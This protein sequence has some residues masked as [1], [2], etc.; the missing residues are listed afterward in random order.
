M[1]TSAALISFDQC[2]FVIYFLFLIP[3]FF[4]LSN[5]HSLNISMSNTIKCPNC[6][7]QFPMEQAVSEEYRK[8]LREKMLEFKKTKEEEMA[9]KE[10]EFQQ[11]LQKKEFDYNNQLQK[12]KSLLQQQI[13]EQLRKRIAGDFENQLALLQ[14]NNKD[15]EERLRLARE[16]EFAFLQREQLL[17]TREQEMELDLQRKIQEERVRMAEEIRKVEEQKN[18]ARDTEHQLRI[19]EYEKQLEDQK[20]L[21]EEMRRKSEQGSMQ[22][23]GEVLEL[24]LEEMLRQQF[25]FDRIEEV[26]KGVK[27]ADC[28]QVIRNGFGVECGKIIFESKRTK[29]FSREWIQKLKADMRSQGADMAV[30]VTTVMPRNMDQ[31]GEMEGIWICSFAEVK[32]LVHVL[33]DSVLKVFNIAKSQENKGDKMQFLYSYLTSHE[34]SEQW[35]A[36]REGF[37]SMKQSIDKERDAMEK[38]WKARE[39][40]LEKVLLNAAHIKGSIEGIAGQDSINFNLLDEGIQDT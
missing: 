11:Q 16:K 19:R 26:G 38:I 13:E 10:L 29:D 20:K 15:Q 9:K 14:Q 37:L 28:V 23:Q 8:E 34:F 1:Q 22:L 21:V 32:A 36:I 27:G 18:Q 7:H 17:K 30:L 3:Y 40:Q 35:K 25:P 2:I 12:E 24:A 31:F 39:K 33:R 5:L 4:R 6:G